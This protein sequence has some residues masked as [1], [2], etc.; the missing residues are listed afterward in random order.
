M[1]YKFLDNV[2]IRKVEKFNIRV[3]G[4]QVIETKDEIQIYN[5]PFKT[6]PLNVGTDRNG[7][8]ILFSNFEDFYDLKNI[9]KVFDE[10]GFW[11][12]IFFGSGLWTRT[13]YKSV[14]QMVA[15]SKILINKKTNKYSI[16]RYWDFN[17]EENKNILNLEMAAKGLYE[18]LDNIYSKLD[19]KKKYTMGISGGLDSRL[20]LAFLSKYIPAQNLDLFTFGFNKKLFE[21][22][23]ACEISKAL[24][25]SKPRFH[26]LTKM[27]YKKAV[28]YL[29]YKSGGQIGINH[30][31]ILDVF[32]E[33]N[34][35]SL[36]NYFSDA[37]FGYACVYPKKKEVIS[38]NYYAKYIKNIDY[39]PKRI[40]YKI[41]DDA[42]LVFEGFSNQS[43]FSCLEEYKYLTERSQ[44]F[45]SLLA[46]L[47]DSTLIL[48]NFDLLTYMLSMPIK[49]RE[50]KIIV[51]TILN[52]YF[53]IIST[54]K[55]KNVS[56]R[57]FNNMSSSSPIK[58]N[59]QEKISWFKFRTLNFLNAILRPLTKGH[60]QILNKL[61]TEEQDRLL[62][63]DFHEDLKRAT[64]KLVQT[65]IM[66]NK[67]KKKWDKLSIR[68]KGISERFNIITI[69]E[70]IS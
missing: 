27:S 57:D 33:N 48:A 45:H 36:S 13:L 20:T 70:L 53:N 59:F 25:F 11:E 67:Q 61:Q 40:K 55:F 1:K 15:A 47:Q 12:I 37:L 19:T 28:D 2:K 35:Q 26:L 52:K 22:K 65:K 21:Y 23:Y 6:E 5:D 68:S 7:N 50:Q 16:Q 54:D 34:R 44:K 29:P 66:T 31:H 43:N 64:R 49:F 58:S 39:L 69:G 60:F 30:C 51:D 8:L 24:G 17:V 9:E 63:R 18:I 46:H 62:Y 3:N 32:K 14:K 41:E 4:L 38:Q 42:K 10:V 56:S